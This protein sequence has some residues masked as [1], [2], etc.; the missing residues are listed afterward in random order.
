MGH[1]DLKK[2]KKIAN[3]EKQNKT[4]SLLSLDKVKKYVHLKKGP[5]NY[6]LNTNIN[7]Q[8]RCVY[9]PSTWVAETGW[10]ESHSSLGYRKSSRPT[11]VT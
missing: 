10:L 2:K 4:V 5:R 8:L 7:S 6:L 11:C 9:N 1:L 3:E